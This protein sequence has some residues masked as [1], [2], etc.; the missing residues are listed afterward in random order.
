VNCD[1]VKTVLDAYADGE[2]LDAIRIREVEAHIA[3]CPECANQLAA[4]RLSRKSVQEG[5]TYFRAPEHLRRNVAAIAVPSIRR[6]P[7]DRRQM[8][9]SLINLSW[10]AA[11]ALVVI[12]FL[13]GRSSTKSLQAE[14][15]SGH[16][17]S[18]QASHLF[19]VAS[20]DRHTVKPWFQGKLDFSPEVPNLAPEGFPL[21]GGRLDY[22]AGHPAA[23]LVYSRGKHTINVFVLSASQITPGAMDQ[24]GYH[25]AHWTEHGLDY[26]AVSDTD[27]LTEFRE[28]FLSATK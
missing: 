11:A 24:D 21:V 16:I 23:A 15:V 8:I 14:L 1:Q 18:M 7:V 20:S 19:D 10:S 6:A 25:I 4:I 13:A 22:I 27:A 12:F 26:Y 5:A 2:F 9:W 28:R 17:R 3:S